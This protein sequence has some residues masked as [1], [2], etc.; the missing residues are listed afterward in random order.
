MK[1]YSYRIISAL[2]VKLSCENFIR[3]NP[4][5]FS[6]ANLSTF[7]VIIRHQDY[8]IKWFSNPKAWGCSVPST[9]RVLLR[10]WGL[11]NC[12]VPL[13]VESDLFRQ[14]SPRNT[15][16]VQ[17]CHWISNVIYGRHSYHVFLCIIHGCPHCIKDLLPGWQCDSVHPGMIPGYHQ[18]S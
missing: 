4:Q 5:K 16:V 8:G 13:V 10:V 9:A 17:Y 1:I 15:R 12:L 7:T 14:E 6:P 18:Y 2:N 3:W 11:L